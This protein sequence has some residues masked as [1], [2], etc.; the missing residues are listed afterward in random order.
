LSESFYPS[1]QPN[2]KDVLDRHRLE[3][4]RSI[5]CHLVGK[6]VTYDRTKNTAS[7]SIAAKREYVDGTVLDFPLLT[8]CPVFHVQG[9]GAWL[10]MPIKFGDHCLVL[11][12]DRDIDAWYH[13][14][15]DKVPGSLRAH[16]LS[17]GIAFVGIQHSKSPLAIEDGI[18][19][20]HG[21]TNKV[22]TSSDAGIAERMTTGKYSV[23]NNEKDL[24]TLIDA[25]FTAIGSMSFTGTAV[26]GGTAGTSATTTLVNAA[27]FTALKAEFALLL[28]AGS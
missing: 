8:D 5:N 16:S 18:V 9:G 3:V 15:Q 27:T 7:I 28:E 1:T 24:K 26:V 17:D 2:L 10:S 6:I 4:S 21:G 19:E 23:K 20:L 12:N 13:S 22:K 11:F 14:G 25:L